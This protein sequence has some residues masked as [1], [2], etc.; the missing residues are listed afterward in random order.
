MCHLLRY[1]NTDGEEDDR[2]LRSDPYMSDYLC[3]QTNL[4]IVKPWSLKIP[5]FSEIKI[6]FSL[7]HIGKNEE[8]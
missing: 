5:N 4:Q 3:K 2:R 6:M 7:K 1:A 8:L